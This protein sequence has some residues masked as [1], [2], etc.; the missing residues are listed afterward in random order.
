[1]AS[2]TTG[3]SIVCSSVCSGADQ[4][5]HQSSASLRRG[6]HRSPVDS[7]YKRPI[8]WNMFPFYDV[9]MVYCHVL[10]CGKQHIQWSPGSGLSLWFDTERLDSYRW[11]LFANK[12]FAIWANI[13][14]GVRKNVKKTKV[15]KLQLCVYFIG[16]SA[17]LNLTD[18]ILCC[19]GFSAIYKQYT[20]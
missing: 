8:A 17:L 2:P 5:K 12:Y 13:S 6:I 16:S 14:H 15:N 9:I 3:V 1:M 11:G 4:R 10:F 19:G 18:N 20:V 7:P